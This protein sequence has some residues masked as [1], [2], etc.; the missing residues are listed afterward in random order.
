[1]LA[2][3]RPSPQCYHDRDWLAKAGYD[4]YCMPMLQIKPAIGQDDTSLKNLIARSDILIFTSQHAVACLQELISDNQLFTSKKAICV[5]ST[6]AFAAQQAGLKVISFTDAPFRNAAEMAASIIREYQSAKLCFTWLS[7]GQVQT[8]IASQ[9]KDNGIGCTR[10][11]LYH[12]EPT[13]ALNLP[14]RQLIESGKLDGVVAL[15]QRSL[16]QFQQLLT[17]NSLWHH[18]HK[19]HLFASSNEMLEGLNTS[20]NMVTIVKLGEENYLQQV[21]SAYRHARQTASENKWNS[22]DN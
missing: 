17:D 8:D 12:A 7:A 10:F 20:F 14:S 13:N 21:V 2:L 19:M 5:G 3:L 18:H 15:S 16:R 22:E 9:L 6:T 1:M 4:G 11:I